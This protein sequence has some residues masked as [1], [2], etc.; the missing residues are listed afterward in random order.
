MKIVF[1]KVLVAP[2]QKTIEDGKGEI[3]LAL[4]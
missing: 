1:L 2:K 3:A 4:P